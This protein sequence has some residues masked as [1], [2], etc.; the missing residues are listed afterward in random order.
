[1]KQKLV[2]IPRFFLLGLFFY[3]IS[4]GDV[5]LDQAERSDVTTKETHALSDVAQYFEEGKSDVQV[6]VRGEVIA[7]LPDDLK[8]SR[9][10]KFIIKLE[11]GMTLLIVH[12]IDL[13]Q[14]ISNLAIGDNVEVYGEYEWNDKGGLI[15]W[16]HHDPKGLHEE[17]WIKHFPQ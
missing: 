12:N 9:H 10:Q 2:N 8:G 6:F 11:Q 15:H 14:R 4:C 13:V 5:K 7:L 3:F 17:G 16:T 1:M